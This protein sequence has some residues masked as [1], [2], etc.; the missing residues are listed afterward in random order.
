M[1]DDANDPANDHATRMKLLHEAEE[2]LVNELAWVIPIYGYAN[3]YLISTK[4]SGFEADP[5]G[6]TMFRYTKLE[7]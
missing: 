2:Y 5:S 1:L 3:P 7:K 4:V 6:Q